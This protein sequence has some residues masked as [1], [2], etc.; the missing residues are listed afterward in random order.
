[1]EKAT[2]EIVALLKEQNELLR[3]LYDM[4]TKSAKS[5]RHR[6]WFQLAL[7]LLPFV[8]VL[9]VVIY[10]YW[11]FSQSLH[12]LTV[13]VTDIRESVGSVITI[14]KDQFSR[15]NEH[16]TTLLSGVR[17][18]IPNLDELTNSFTDLL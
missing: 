7:K 15:L 18:L 2:S 13:Q 10:L 12:E 9:A 17:S 16:F 6:E 1:M 5:A 11:S 4:Q 3:Q 8:V 14:M